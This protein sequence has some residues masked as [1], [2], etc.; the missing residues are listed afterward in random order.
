MNLQTIYNF[1]KNNAICSC[2]CGK[3]RLYYFYKLEEFATT[4]GG[5]DLSDFS[6]YFKSILNT[7]KVNIYNLALQSNI[8]RSTIHKVASG[9]RIPNRAFIDKIMFHIPMTPVEKKLFLDI[10]QVTRDGPEIYERRKRVQ[11]IISDLMQLNPSQDHI[12]FS[13]HH[14][15]GNMKV[16]R[17][18]HAIRLAVKQIIEREAFSQNQPRIWMRVPPCELIDISLIALT[19]AG[20]PE[21]VEWIH[22]L[23]MDSGNNPVHQN[24]NLELLRNVLPF[25]Y[26]SNLKYQPHY[27]Y[28][29]KENRVDVMQTMP[30]YILTS[31]SLLNINLEAKTAILS[32]SAELLNFFNE[33]FL[34]Q[35]QYTLPLSAAKDT[36]ISILQHFIEILKSSNGSICYYEYS[37]NFSC[38]MDDAFVRRRI[39]PDLENREKVVENVA[40]RFHMIRSRKEKFHTYFTQY[41]LDKFVRT[42][43]LVNTIPKYDSPYS[44]EDR[45]YLL[46]HLIE[47]VEKNRVCARLLTLPMSE[48][49]ENISITSFGR[50]GLNIAAYNMPGQD[51]KTSYISETNLTVAFQDYLIWLEDSDLVLS[52]EDTLTALRKAR[53]SLQE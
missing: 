35:K 4:E 1:L 45:I 29:T 40:I 24:E 22:I 31:E 12:S 48:M 27:Y 25:C 2:Y 16:I 8:D 9:S 7:K 17:G 42:G 11:H 53:N 14:T 10:Y 37:P 18:A 28:E 50:D 5:V 15:E 38:V 6:E 49:S 47:E 39:R 19:C 33:E 20:A 13:L 23:S 43:V 36:A 32:M 41:G 51:M 52:E 26:L 21:P 46:S 3:K 44:K 34:R 30:F